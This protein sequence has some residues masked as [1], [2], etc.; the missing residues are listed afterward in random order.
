MVDA[1][2]LHDESGVAQTKPKYSLAAILN[3]AAP[4]SMIQT[5][6]LSLK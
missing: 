1:R 3:P 6:L 4:Q 5:T 2:R